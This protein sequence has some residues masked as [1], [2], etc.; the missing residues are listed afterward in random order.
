[1]S[2]MQQLFLGQG[3][4]A[5]K[6]FIDS[7]FSTF[8]YTGNA[9]N[10]R[11]IQ[12][13]VDLSEGGLVWLKDRKVA[14]NHL[15]VDSE[16]SMNS[17]RWDY[18]IS[19]LTGAPYSGPVL[20][21]FENDGFKLHSNWYANQ[22]GR[23]FSSWSFA[24]SKG[25]FDVVTFSESTTG[26][27]TVN[28]SLGCI[29]GMIIY[30]RYDA[31]GTW[32]VWH[33]SIP[34]EHGYFNGNSAFSNSGGNDDSSP[35]TIIDDVTAT[36]F[37]VKMGTIGAGIGAD[38][39]A[40]VFAGG[41]SDAATARSVNLA[42]GVG[43]N[44][45]VY[46]T[47]HAAHGIA[48][49]GYGTGDFT[50]EA[51]F[52]ADDNSTEQRI[53]NHRVGSTTHGGIYFNS[54]GNFIYNNNSNNSISSS[55]KIGKGQ[56]Y[57]VAVSR[58]SNTTRL[59]INGTLEGSVT[60]NHNYADTKVDIGSKAG[61]NNFEGDLSNVRIIK[62]TGLY[63]SSFR[64]LT[65]PLTNVTNTVLLCCNNSSVTGS[66]VVPSSSAIEANSPSGLTAITDSPFDDPAGFIFGE[67]GSESV[68]K[69]GMYKTDSNEDATLN[70]GWEPQFLLVKRTDAGQYGA[71]WMIVDSVRGLPNA[72]DVQDNAAGFCNVLEANTTDTETNTSRLGITPTG[73]Y[74]DQFGSNREFIFLAIRRSDGYVGKPVE[75]ATDAFAMDTGN[76]SSY[77]FDAGF[78]V[79]MGLY[80]RPTQAESW[81][82]GTRLT[83][84]RELQTNLN[85][86]E[87]TANNNFDSNTA[88]ATQYNSTYQ[89][90]MWARGQGMDAVAYKGNSVS[91][92]QISHSMNA[93]P[94][95]IFIK[96]RDDTTDWTVGHF[97]ANGGTNPWNY[98]LELNNTQAGISQ[99]GIWNNTAPTST[100]FT[101]GDWTQ[102]N[103]SSG[104]YLALLFSSVSGI[105]KCGYFAGTGSDLTISLGFQP[106]FVLI[107][108]VTATASWHQFDTV[109]GIASGT[110]KVLLLN[111]DNAQTNTEDRIDLTSDGMTLHA[112]GSTNE[113]NMNFV[114][115]AHA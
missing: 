103:N 88:W 100:H 44:L 3:S 42:T 115:Y 106:R 36:S 20:N 9:T 38:Y 45:T 99:V 6:T 57:H 14:E 12:N 1:M 67:S 85:S 26:D 55:Q 18:L 94:Q 83:G 78:P 24:K 52:R 30:K 47:V 25:F 91:G 80:R 62:G 109:R 51:Y 37:D 113:I 29:P 72:Q 101:L 54:S 82:I 87:F 49:F 61:S 50:W 63:T 110:D 69:C 74:A 73:F 90:W 59:F 92:T 7:V 53:I 89:S 102:V 76:N 70:L 66:T 60:D 8:L 84:K 58:N 68:I 48:G 81:Y 34:L 2:P 23:D 43:S 10:D 64:P 39:V 104:K 17:A 28:H 111:T 105:S 40:Y 56:W 108:D 95:M 27:Q 98:Y 107:K 32:Y 22:T 33:R 114:Y 79:D 93:V 41:E 4:V 31:N 21:S 97:G 77:S 19:N 65:E 11:H 112:Y 16:W 5:K 35:Q 75:L 46:S 96:R 71:D 15:F 13:G 86:S